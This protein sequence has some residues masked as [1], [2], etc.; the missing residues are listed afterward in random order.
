MGAHDLIAR[1]RYNVAEGEELEPIK[2]VAVEL[3]DLN[4][5]MVRRRIAIDGAPFAGFTLI[6][7]IAVVVIVGVVAVVAMTAMSTMQRQA[8]S[9]NAD[10]IVGAFKAAADQ[11]R[12]LCIARSDGA[13]AID[14]P[15]LADGTL[16]FNSQCW[17][18]G[19]GF[20]TIASTAAGPS[21]GAGNECSDLWQ[22]LIVSGPSIIQVPS[23]PAS[24]PAGYNMIT[25]SFAQSCNF[26]FLQ[27]NG[28]YQMAVG[29][30]G[31]MVRWFQ[32]DTLSGLI[33]KSWNLGQ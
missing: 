12:S 13:G 3:D 26:H 9:A 11:A 19:T 33:Y 31:E 7:L 20:P 5:R 6:E 27:S 24:P 22:K 28:R 4:A 17:P 14:L 1:R 30:W 15:G 32:F 10:A 2:A 23:P 21:G 29:G 8:E 18:V 16:D 25:S